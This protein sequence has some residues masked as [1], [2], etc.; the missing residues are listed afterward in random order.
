MDKRELDREILRLLADSRKQLDKWVATLDDTRVTDEEREC[1]RKKT[2]DLLIH[3]R[4]QIA[5]YAEVDKNQQ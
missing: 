1:E 3:T 5:A 4:K 2:A